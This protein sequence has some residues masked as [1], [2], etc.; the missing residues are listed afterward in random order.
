MSIIKSLK[1][2]NTKGLLGIVD[3]A[4]YR[5]W[6]AETFLVGGAGLQSFVYTGYNSSLA[7]ITKCPPLTAII[8]KKAQAYINGKT[9][10][11]DLKGK[12]S[13][14][15]FANKIRKL[16]AKPN[17]LQSWKQFE[18]QNYF[19]Q[20]TFGFCIVLPILPVGWK[21][22]ENAT[23]IWNIPGHMIVPK[24]TNKLWYQ[25][26]LKGIVEKITLVYKGVES[27][28]PL[29][30]IYI[31][32]DFTPSFNTMIFPESRICSLEMPINNIIGAYESRNVLINYRGAL[33]IISSETDKSGFI[34]IK[35][36]DK[37]QLQA[38]FRR[39]GLKGQQWKF[40]ITSAAVKWQ[41]MSVPTRDLMLFEEVIDNTMAICDSY[42]YP[43]PLMSS[44]RTNS[45]GGNNADPN[46]KL[47]YQDAIIPEADSMYDQWNIFFKCEENKVKLEKDYSHVAVLQEDKGQTAIARNTLGQALDR[48]FKNNWITYNR[49]LEL[50]EEDTIPDMD[51]YYNDLL[52]EGYVFGAQAAIVQAPADQTPPA[53]QN[54][55]SKIHLNGAAKSF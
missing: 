28:L 10:V 32:K 30:Q 11:M 16:Q 31:F 35:Q 47:L 36:S 25:T 24:E 42:S 6:M 34:P 33:G 39:Y 21:G 38:D 14:S 1:A 40:I 2:L 12:E 4:T 15:E 7:A 27:E 29:D 8:N 41:S 55:K 52:T 45:L 53:S 37:E 43:Y 49:V 5:D 17:P 20:Q 26:D 13:F 54:G 9:W 18:A 19:F 23:S 22:N 48:E 50:L 46:K 44:A 51:K 3:P